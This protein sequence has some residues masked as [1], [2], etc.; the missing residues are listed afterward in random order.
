MNEVFLVAGRRFPPVL[1]A[2]G[3]SIWKKPIVEQFFAGSKVVFLHNASRVPSLA[4]LIVWGRKTIP[5]KLKEGV[6][7]IR[8]ED[9]FLRSVGLGADLIRPVSWVIDTRGIYYDATQT[10]DLEVLLQTFDFSP[11]LLNR[12]ALIRERVVNAG[13]TKYNVGSGE[14]IRPLGQQRIILVPGQ[15]ESDASLRFGALGICTNLGLLRAVRESNPDAYVLY[16]P[17][18]DVLA[19]LKAQGKGE[20]AALQWCDEV[21]TNVSMGELLQSVDEVHVLTSLAGFEALMRGKAVTCYGLPFYA[22]WGLTQDILKVSRRTRHLNLDELIAGALLLYPTY[23]NHQTGEI[24]TPEKALDNLL[25]WRNSASLD[26][27]WWRKVLRRILRVT[28]S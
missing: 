6:H 3:F 9:G 21:V 24:T 4:T 1:Y 27:P 8:L 16:K 23:V 12:A 5:G 11:E 10:S 19:G 7:L 20:D 18:P 28:V 2:C 13:L 17:H 26:V 22:G 15:V 25:E 14:W